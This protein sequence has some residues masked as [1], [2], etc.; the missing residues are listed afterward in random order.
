MMDEK[1]APDALSP[2]LEDESQPTPDSAQSLSPGAKDLQDRP[3]ESVEHPFQVGEEILLNG[4]M[5]FVHRIAENAIVLQ[6]K[7]Y[8]KPA[9]PGVQKKAFQ[10]GAQFEWKGWAFQ[11]VGIVPPHFKK[12]WPK[13][14]KGQPCQPTLKV[15]RPFE[16]H[17]KP[18]AVR[19][20][21][22]GLPPETEP[23]P[24]EQEALAEQFIAPVLE[25]LS[26]PDEPNA[27][28]AWERGVEDF[29][30]NV[31]ENANAYGSAL[32]LPNEDETRSYQRQYCRS[33]WENGWKQ[34]RDAAKSITE[35]SPEPDAPVQ[36]K[37]HASADKIF[38]KPV[39]QSD[40][41]KTP[42]AVFGEYRDAPE[43]GRR[44]TR[45]IVIPGEG[46]E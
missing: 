30:R 17:I 6:A 14:R 45:S 29:F 41:L 24:Q 28:Q 38:G 32:I 8:N 46:G 21:V 39:V 18:F 37:E 4:R 2:I 9:P 22:L 35:A 31:P 23:T 25:R 42:D 33:F 40:E 44:A 13:K 20:E 27:L 1:E 26:P 11:I 7:E 10:L 12:K 16:L 34:A 36:D 43:S 15:I 3:F 19:R 5:L